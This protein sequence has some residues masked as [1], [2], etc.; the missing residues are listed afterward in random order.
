MFS[1][2]PSYSVSAIGARPLLVGHWEH[3][4]ERR[5]DWG[6]YGQLSIRYGQTGQGM[7]SLAAI[8]RY[9]RLFFVCLSF[10]LLIGRLID[11]HFWISVRVTMRLGSI[12]TCPVNVPVNARRVVL[13]S[14]VLSLANSVELKFCC[15][16]LPM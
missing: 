16:W 12:F 1:G 9:C 14:T 3:L 13:P 6:H 10:D 2:S 4:F 7:S 11:N 15:C 5:L 8:I